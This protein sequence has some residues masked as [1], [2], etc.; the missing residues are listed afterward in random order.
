MLEERQRAFGWPIAVELWLSGAGCATFLISFIF[1][2]LGRCELIAR[3][4]GILGPLLVGI[5]SVLLLVDLGCKSQVYRL[6]YK[7]SSSWMSKGTW[8]LTFFVLLSLAYSVPA[9][10]IPWGAVFVSPSTKR[11]LPG[12][13]CTVDIYPGF[14]FGVIK[15]IP[16]WN[17]PAL[18]PVFSLSSLYTG[19]A[20]VLLIAC[21][22]LG[23]LESEALLACHWLGIAGITLIV[24]QL[25]AL[26]AYVEIGRNSSVS[27]VK[28]VR[29]LRTPRLV[30]GALIVGLIVPLCVL[31]Y[32]LAV[33]GEP[34]CSILS[35]V[36]GVLMLGGSLFLRHS[37]IKAR[38]YLP[39]VLIGNK[40]YE[41]TL[42]WPGG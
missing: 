40:Y 37:I 3:I 8:I 32:S 6:F 17:T 31:S 38:V 14:L 18:P 5:G 30:G 2:L 41:G 7:V 19:V 16:V 21:L 15:C 28:S 22:P 12:V 13:F 23:I 11:P 10:W 26:G 9:L 20:I 1:D 25:L 27:F 24:V 34:V 35:S 36:A 42:E 33:N 29:L 4:G 39:I